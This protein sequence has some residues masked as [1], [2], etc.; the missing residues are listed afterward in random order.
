ME[1]GVLAKTVKSPMPGTL[2]KLGV[3]K[4][5]ELK[6]GSMI[7]IVEAMKMEVIKLIIL[8]IFLIVFL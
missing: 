2:I 7:C 5:D 8:F 6:K 3:K 1:S 4:G